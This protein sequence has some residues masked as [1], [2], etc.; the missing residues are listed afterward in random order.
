[1]VSGTSICVVSVRLQLRRLLRLILLVGLGFVV[2][3]VGVVGVLVRFYSFPL[4]VR[5]SG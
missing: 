1:M 4:Q 3:V 5:L 2:E